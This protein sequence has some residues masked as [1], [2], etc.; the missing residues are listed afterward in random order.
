MLLISECVQTRSPEGGLSCR[1]L[2]RG[3]GRRQNRRGPPKVW[4]GLA[5]LLGS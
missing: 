4:S 5:P 1:N 3:V 2:E